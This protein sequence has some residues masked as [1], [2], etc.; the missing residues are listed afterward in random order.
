MTFADLPTQSYFRFSSPSMPASRYLK[1]SDTHYYYGG[2]EKEY[3]LDPQFHTEEVKDTATPAWK[4]EEQRQRTEARRTA[5]KIAEAKLTSRQLT[6]QLDR[7]REEYAKRAHHTDQLDQFNAI[8]TA[9][10]SEL[11]SLPPTPRKGA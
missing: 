7:L 4:Q 9:M 11:D 10:L 6:N 5:R 3:R 2:T 8:L 1:T